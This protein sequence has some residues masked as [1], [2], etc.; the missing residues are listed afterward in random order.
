MKTMFIVVN[1]MHADDRHIGEAIRRHHTL[2]S[3]QKSVAKIQRSVKRANGK[4]S[5][6]P[7][8]IVETNHDVTQ[9]PMVPRSCA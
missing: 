8:I 1:T 3:A 7:M 2:E 6:L 9:N 4:D 5:Y